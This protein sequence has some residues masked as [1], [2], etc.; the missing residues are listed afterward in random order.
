LSDKTPGDIPRPSLKHRVD[1]PPDTH[2]SRKLRCDVE[3]K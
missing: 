2:V 1:Y 3:N